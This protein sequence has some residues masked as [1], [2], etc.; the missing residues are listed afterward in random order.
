MI[1][2]QLFMLCLCVCMR[3]RCVPPCQTL[4]LMGCTSPQVM[5][6]HTLATKAMEVI[7]EVFPTRSLAVQEDRVRH[8]SIARRSPWSIPKFHAMLHAAS[9]ILLMGNWA[10]AEAQVVEACHVIVK[11]LAKNT[12]Q[13]PTQ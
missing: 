12:N 6:L 9:S 3:S 13:K 2:H 7:V 8:R 10:T 5:R 11:R 1:E 4:L